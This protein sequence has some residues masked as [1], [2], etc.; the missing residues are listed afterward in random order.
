MPACRITRSGGFP[1]RSSVTAGP[2]GNNF[3]AEHPGQPADGVS[4]RVLD[5]IPAVRAPGHLGG[6]R[7]LLPGDRGPDGLKVAMAASAPGTRSSLSPEPCSRTVPPNASPPG[8]R[9]PARKPFTW[10]FVLAVVL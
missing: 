10:R 9:E 4:S 8:A 2:D 3:S 6:G 1:S 5:V 7:S